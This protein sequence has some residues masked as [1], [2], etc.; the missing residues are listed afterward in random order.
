MP[1]AAQT[2]RVR[3]LRAGAQAG[4]CRPPP[5]QHP[6]LQR[7]FLTRAPTDVIN[8]R[9]LR[10]KGVKVDD[11]FA[12]Q[13]KAACL[14]NLVF[15]DGAREPALKLERSGGAEAMK[16]LRGLAELRPPRGCLGAL[17]CAPGALAPPP[18]AGARSSVFARAL[19]VHCLA[20]GR[21]V[22][23]MLDVVEKQVTLETGELQKPW[24]RSAL[25]RRDICIVPGDSAAHA[26]PDDAASDAARAELA[27]KLAAAEAARDYPTAL[28]VLR[29][30]G[31]DSA[32]VA[33][34]ATLCMGRISAA[35]GGPASAR[36]AGGAADVL[37]AV[38]A[39]HKAD[40]DVA[41]NGCWALMSLAYSDD[42]MRSAVGGAGGVEAAIGALTAHAG[43]ARVCA[44]AARCLAKLFAGGGGDNAA[45]G[46]DAGALPALT[47]ALK[48]HGAG[49][50]AVAKRCAAAIAAACHGAVNREKALAAH[51]PAALAAA[52][53][54]PHAPGFLFP[55]VAAEC[56]K[57]LR[58]LAFS[59]DGPGRGAVRSAGGMRLATAALA[60][61]FNEANATES[62]MWLLTVLLADTNASAA[63][64]QR[65]AA[66]EAGV[67]PA[68]VSALRVHAGRAVVVGLAARL[69]DALAAGGDEAAVAAAHKQPEGFLASAAHA[70]H[71]DGEE[72]A[73]AAEAD[74]AAERRKSALGEGVTE[75]LADAMTRHKGNIFVATT[76][77]A[78]MQRMGA[79]T[80]TVA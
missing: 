55:D 43:D 59:A 66:A 73:A 64:E 50:A 1:A 54:E 63:R 2:A 70:L 58:V 13:A 60:R 8:D 51:A 34:Q 29:E 12:L 57:A 31:T 16:K 49:D 35:G 74:A 7:V 5:W 27:A 46:G 26:H 10:T 23:H 78:A 21:G 42:A 56:C 38:V 69:L 11:V 47:A 61:H 30:S 9:A 45:R 37:C 32:D 39:A 17:S 20:P 53:A 71:L 65:K 80:A 4:A 14:M 77:E 52:M 24:H 68:C 48:T 62:T 22:S 75:A 15:L 76:G 18:A 33:K 79:A 3:P 40:V 36:A 19:A 41:V 25:L 44:S 6:P 28:A 67:V 72:R